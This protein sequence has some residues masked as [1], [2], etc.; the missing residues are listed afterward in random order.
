MSEQ[1]KGLTRRQMLAGSGA[2]AVALGVVS[3]KESRAGSKGSWDFE[4]DVLVVGAG[5]GGCAAA[6]TAAVAGDKVVLL[7]KGSFVGGT[8]A[9]SA[10]VLW[11]PNNFVLKA[12]GVED[13]REDCLAYMARY[14]FPGRYNPDL[15]S[16]G[17][18]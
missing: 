2:A 17:L 3:L 13:S 7:E 12:N 1:G 16:M 6:I 15:P 9:K 10:G 4:T 18:E 11:I 14:S 5:A 8:A